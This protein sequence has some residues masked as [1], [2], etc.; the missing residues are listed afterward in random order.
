MSDREPT[1]E[2]RARAALLKYVGTATDLAERL[3]PSPRMLAAVAA[4]IRAAADAA[5]AREREMR[6]CGHPMAC[7]LGGGAIAYCSAC[8]RERELGPCGK[9]PRACHES[10]LSPLGVCDMTVEPV[11]VKTGE[12]GRIVEAHR[13]SAC[14]REASAVEE[15]RERCMKLQIEA[16]ARVRRETKRE[17]AEIVRKWG[18]KDARTIAAEIERQEE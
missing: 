9:H 17:D 3:E 15:M 4:E 14:A 18:T 7:L 8:A 12:G 11:F 1:P 13:C 6:E 2:E 16:V 10:V 5:A